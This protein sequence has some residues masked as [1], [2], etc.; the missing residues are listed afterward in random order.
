LSIYP[1]PTNGYVYVSGINTDTEYRIYDKLGKVVSK[2]Q[3]NGK[4]NIDG[5]AAGMYYLK[6][7]K[8]TNSIKFVVK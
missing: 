3:T 4:I 8:N 1:N 2:G 6:L 7:D 5:L